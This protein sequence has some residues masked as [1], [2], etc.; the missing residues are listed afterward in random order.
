MIRDKSP[1]FTLF[2]DWS[3]GGDFTI[4]GRQIEVLRGK[5]SLVVLS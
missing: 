5:V 3:E 4:H 2:G 1:P